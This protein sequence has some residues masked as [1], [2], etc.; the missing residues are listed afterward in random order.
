MTQRLLIPALVIAFGLAACDKPS[1]PPAA[2]AEPAAPAAAATP[3]TPAAPATPLVALDQEGLRLVAGDT[4]STRL[5]AFDRPS[6]E[7]V[8][9][10][11]GALGAPKSRS[12]N[13]E[14]GA[15]PIDFVEWANGLQVMSQGGKFVGWSFD[16]RGTGAKLTTMDGVGVGSSRAEL[17]AALPSATVEESTLGQEFTAGDYSGILSGP[18]ADAKIEAI[19]AGVNCV[20]R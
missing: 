1:Q 19:W 10:L 5:L 18:G 2:P 8:T 15:G 14:C 11:T 20:F 12:T 3:A 13:S 16:G 4:G 9:A 6:D 7:A 17:K